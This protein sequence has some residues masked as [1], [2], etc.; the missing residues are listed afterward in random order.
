M[1]L[2]TAA[3]D[4]AIEHADLRGTNSVSAPPGMLNLI[5]AVDR[6]DVASIAVA[7]VQIADGVAGEAEPLPRRTG[8]DWNRCASPSAWGSCYSTAAMPPAQ[9]SR[10][11]SGP[12]GTSPTCF[13]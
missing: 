5:D 7:A 13:T 1:V 8:P 10:F 6:D 3:R 2:R 11:E 4:V 9:A 12:R